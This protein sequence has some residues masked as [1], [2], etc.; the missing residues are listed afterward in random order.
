MKKI[1]V[2]SLLSM[3]LLLIASG[4]NQDEKPSAAKKEPV[5]NEKDKERAI[6]MIE[7]LNER[8]V[9]FENEANTVISKGGIEVGDNEAFTQ[10]VNDMSEEMVIEP[11]LEEFPESLI[12]GRGNMKVT[13]IPKSSDDCA[14]GNCHYDSIAVP[15][16][17]VDEEDWDTYSSEDFDITELTLSKVVLTY[18]SE[19][20]ND[21]T[22]IS[23]VKGESGTLY[24]SFNPIINSLNFN[25]KEIDDEFLSIKSDVPESEVETEERAFKQEVEEVLAEYPPLQ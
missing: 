25:L 2:I 10:Q 23:F 6:A 8:L 22:Y 24:F 16:L 12:N 7:A 21:S 9:L 18:S 14:F 5:F 20:D 3:V 19:T 17:Q 1:F 4:C 11:F 15:T 13:F